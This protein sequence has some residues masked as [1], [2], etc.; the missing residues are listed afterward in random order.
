[1]ITSSFVLWVLVVGAVCG[2]GDLDILS[3]KRVKMAERPC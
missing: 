1:M 2:V 3:K